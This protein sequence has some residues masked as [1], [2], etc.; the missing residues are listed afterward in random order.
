[1][2]GGVLKKRELKFNE[3]QT[4]SE[5]KSKPTTKIST[6]KSNQLMCLTSDSEEDMDEEDRKL[7]KDVKNIEGMLD[8][9]GLQQ[10]LGIL[11]DGVDD[12]SDISDQENDTDTK[13]KQQNLNKKGEE[14]KQKAKLAQSYND[15]DEDDEWI[16]DH[17]G[18]RRK[19]FKV[20]YR[21]IKEL[22]KDKI[23]IA[24]N[25]PKDFAYLRLTRHDVLRTIDTSLFKMF[26]RK[27][28]RRKLKDLVYEYVNAEIQK[29]SNH[30]PV[31]LFITSNSQNIG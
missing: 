17:T 23:V 26:Q 21:E 2:P 4:E 15:G 8:D 18:I 27:N 22:L 3:K 9:D 11:D 28:L 29:T 1:M 24:H 12:N 20:M 10:E 19:P 25:L 16:L 7:M 6:N 31:S 30:S 5:P 14:F 13:P